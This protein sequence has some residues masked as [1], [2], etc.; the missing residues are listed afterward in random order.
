MKG[1]INYIWSIAAG[2]LLLALLSYGEEARFTASVSGNAVTVGEQIQVT[3]ELQGGG[4]RN[5]QA[6]NF[7]GFSVLMGPN[8]STQMSIV[9]GS[10]SQ[11]ISYTY[12]IQ[13]DKEGAYNLGSASIEV[14]G[15]KL[16]SN[17]ITINVGKGSSRSQSRGNQQQGQGSDDVVTG[18]KSVFLKASV[19]KANAYQG[20]AITVTYK[21]CTKVTLVNYAISKIP[22]FNGFFST[23]IQM[24]QQ[25]EFHMENIDGV[26]Y[27]V[28]DVK[29]LILFPQHSGTLTIDPMEGEVIARVQVKRQQQR[30]NDPF[31]LFN[32]PFFNNPF[33]N[34]SARDVKVSMKSEQVKLNIRELPGNAPD[35]FSGAVGKFTIESSLDKKE[36]KAHDGVT[37]KIKISGKGNIKL[38]DPPKMSFPAE[39]ESYDPKI[40]STVNASMAGVTGSKTFEY[41]LVPRNAG[42]YKIPVGDFSYFDLEKNA[43][44]KI[45][46]Q[47]FVLKVLKGEESS[48]PVVTG[49][50]KNDVQFIG[51]DI[52]FI[53]TAPLVLP[54]NSPILYNTPLFYSAMT[55]PVL[56]FML[57]LG[58]RKRKEE[59]EG[60]VSLI[61]SRGAN[62]VA[63][64]RLS[65]AKKF[66]DQQN[67]TGFLDEMFRA[68]WGFV[69]DKLQIPVS[70]LSKENVANAMAARK[71]SQETVGG[72][73]SALDR[74]ELAR[75]APGVASS[76]EEIY[77]SGINVISKLEEEIR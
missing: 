42:E 69:S 20:E 19:S 71:V 43:Y 67:R 77:K 52:R 59:R 64:K 60:N 31:D 30:S 72:F 3:F 33:F 5:F 18:G 7:S 68:L 73:I 34:N 53:K 39:F 27:K 9:N 8:Q 75:F 28:A 76:I 38:I 49:V 56:L 61:K 17:S 48:A 47:E 74:I 2:L 57:L 37:L 1:K 58:W 26:N 45:A 10:V 66:L 40:N 50:S 32:D 46:G 55:A 24:P 70:E 35:G 21:L 44:Q 12:V 16:V 14:N 11:S 22:S 65:T 23:D 15:K 25:L 62:K 4:G 13:A 54:Q 6:P 51:K 41:L 63:R 36:V 29:K